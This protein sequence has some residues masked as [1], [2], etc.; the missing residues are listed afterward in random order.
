MGTVAGERE[1]DDGEEE[2]YGA[3]D[4]ENELEHG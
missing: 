2:L 3:H 1:D 4:E